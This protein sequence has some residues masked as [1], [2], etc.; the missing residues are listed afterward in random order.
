[1]YAALD[2]LREVVEGAMSLACDVLD[3]GIVAGSGESWFC[4]SH[5]EWSRQVLSTPGT[6]G[7]TFCWLSSPASD[8]VVVVQIDKG[9]VVTS[10]LYLKK[11]ILT[12]QNAD[13]SEATAAISS[14][15][16]SSRLV[17]GRSGDGM[18][19]EHSHSK[20]TTLQQTLR[21]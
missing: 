2:A 9:F 7:L 10:R 12:S 4:T 6:R 19:L 15:C 14:Q 13:R 11:F 18:N 17:V 3:A 16:S 20:H 1:M 21:D 8:R 5:L